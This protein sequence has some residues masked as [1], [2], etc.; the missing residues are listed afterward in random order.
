[1]SDTSPSGVHAGSSE[2][3]RVSAAGESGIKPS[4]AASARRRIDKPLLV[5]DVRA[6]HDTGVSRYGLSLLAEAA[7][8]LTEV[9]WRLV[10]VARP[11]QED[12]VRAAV[13]GLRAQV[14]CDPQA[15]FVRHSLWLRRMLTIQKASLYFTSH[16]TV[17]RQCPVPFVFT[18]H[19]L[20]HLQLPEFSYTDQLFIDRFGAAE[21]DLVRKELAA[22]S[23]W[24]EPGEGDALF[25]R[26][27]RA[28]NGY[29]AD[30]AARIVTV[31]HF[32][33]SQIESLLGVAAERLAVVPGG[34]DTN[35]FFPRDASI[36]R[37]IREKYS[38]SGPYLMFVG[39]THPHKRLPWLVDQLLTARN[40]FPDMARLVA[41]GGY[42]ERVPEVTRLLARYDAEDFVVFTGHVGD[43]DLAALYTGAS[44]LVTASLNE[45]SGLPTLEAMAC[46]CQVIATDIRS[47]RETLGDTAA[48]YAPANGEQLRNLAGEALVG[49]LRT[50]SDTFRPPSW[51]DAGHRLVEV[52]ESAA[53]GITDAQ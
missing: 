50:R 34:V 31:S 13:H 41:V 23:R 8:L 40:R 30:R 21:L 49:R 51:Q 14:V 3:R 26:Y 15:G 53:S 7:P 52:L 6:N 16:Y 4:L 5:F 47:F 27:F 1:V 12:R 29:L 18:I 28:L 44:A 20:N 42:A 46:G 25:T 24:D 17:D 11:A 32:S 45:G 38:L 9:G 22:L 37:A 48:Y 39:L 36:V 2:S 10:V 35:V 43:G 19:D 33:A